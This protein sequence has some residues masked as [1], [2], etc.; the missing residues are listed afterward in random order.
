MLAQL[1]DRYGERIVGGGVAASGVLVELL[2]TPRGAAEPTW[3]LIFTTPD[4]RSCLVSAGEGWREAVP[5]IPVPSPSREKP[6]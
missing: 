4:G 3:S 6:A 5:P 1:G 2:T